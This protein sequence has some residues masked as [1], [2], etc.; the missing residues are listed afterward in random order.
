MDMDMD[1]MNMTTY[2]DGRS[3]LDF[4]WICMY[5]CVLQAR[6]GVRSHALIGLFAPVLLRCFGSG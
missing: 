5:V 2:D 6:L 4:C 3:S 1:T